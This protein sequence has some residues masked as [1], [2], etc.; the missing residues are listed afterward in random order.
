MVDYA[1]RSLDLSFH[2]L[3]DPTRRAILARIAQGDSTVSEL[4]SPFDMSLAA[5]SKHLKVLERAKFVKKIKSGRII[6][7]KATL[8]PLN[9]MTR[10]LEDLGRFWS[11]QLDSLESYLANQLDDE[12]R[13]ES[14]GKR[15]TSGP[16]GRSR[17]KKLK[18]LG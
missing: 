16:A 2:A 12:K 13:D 10:V 14:Q 9:E 5:V 15:K 17:K 1:S 11:A 6:V 18:V 7:C 8:E 3:A 4:A